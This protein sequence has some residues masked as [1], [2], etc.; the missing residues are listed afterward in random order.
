VLR[1]A[2]LSEHESDGWSA[3]LAQWLADGMAAY[4]W[5]IH[6]RLMPPNKFGYWLFRT[7]ELRVDDS[8]HRDH[9]YLE[10][11]V[12]AAGSA[13]DDLTGDL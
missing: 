2:Q 13:V 10:D 3:E 9:K 11:A 1:R 12:Y 6:T 5:I 8:L 4:R 7:L